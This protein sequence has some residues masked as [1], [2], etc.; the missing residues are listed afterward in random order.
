MGS[1]YFRGE[2]RIV[3]APVLTPQVVDVGDIV[4]LSSGNV[5]RASD[6]TW[7]TN[8]A[9]TQAA[10]A[11]TFLGVSAQRKDA[12]IARIHGNSTD[13]VIRVDTSGIFEFDCASATFAVGDFVGPAKQTGDFMENQKVAA[14]ATESLAIGRVAKAGASITKVLVELL[15]V[16]MPAA[17]QA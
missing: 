13:N 11:P 8:I 12:N 17:R 14:V 9:T 7:N 3:I 5:V 4:G 2:P 16:K 1:R 15:S 10:F 6:T